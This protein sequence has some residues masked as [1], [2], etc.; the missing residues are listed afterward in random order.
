MKRRTFLVGVGGL[1]TVP[2]FEQFIRF[3]REEGRPMLLTPSTAS[4]TLHVY[5]P[6]YPDEGGYA[7]TLGPIELD[8]PPTTW[9][10]FLSRKGYDLDDPEVREEIELDWSVT[11]DR[12]KE[13]CPAHY[14]YREWAVSQSP[15]ARAF[16][17]LESLDLGP[18][19]KGQK[20]AKGRLDF[21]EGTAPGDCQR[22]VECK[23]LVTVSLLQ[24][25][26]REL[27]LPIAVKMADPDTF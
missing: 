21:F 4:E 3:V 20:N 13:E 26:L 19:L 6:I 2:L 10:E 17:L 25:R 16:E 14:V 9:E 23:D 27:D 12:F 7:V 22:W 8:P 18:E 24:A 5:P 1:I 15:S 11:P